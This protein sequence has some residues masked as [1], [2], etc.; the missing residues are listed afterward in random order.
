M[1]IYDDKGRKRTR[2]MQ[3][4]SKVDNGLTRSMLIFSQ[5]ADIRGMGL[6][7]VETDD[8]DDQQV[9]LPALKR[10]QRIAGSKR[11]ERFAGSDFAY[12]DLGTRDVDRYKARLLETGDSTWTI[13]AVPMDESPYSRIIFEL[14]RTRYT[15]RR[16][17]YFDRNNKRWKVLESRDFEQVG[18]ETWRANFMRM[19]DLL[20][21]RYTTLEIR[22]RNINVTLPDAMFTERELKRGVR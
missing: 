7:T 8:G 22:E 12:E 21:N 3:L 15:V 10:T 14:D 13:E 5:P 19:E 1:E 11:G 9:Y 16:A 2:T 17:E 6:L 18:P 20:D 4:R